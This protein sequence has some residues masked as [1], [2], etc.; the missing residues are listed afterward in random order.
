MPN[1]KQKTYVVRVMFDAR[2]AGNEFGPF[3]DIETA[4]QCLIVLSGRADVIAATLET[5]GE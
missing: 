5:K 4:E 2:D 1:A 3:S